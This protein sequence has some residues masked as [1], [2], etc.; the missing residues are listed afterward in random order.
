[1]MVVDLNI[2]RLSPNSFVWWIILWPLY[3][4]KSDPGKGNDS[5][6]LLLCLT[7]PFFQTVVFIYKHITIVN[8]DFCVVSKWLEWLID[9]AR[10]IIY[11]HNMF[12]MQAMIDLPLFFLLW[13]LIHCF[14][15]WSTEP[16]AI[17]LYYK[18]I[19]IVNDD[20]SDISKG[21]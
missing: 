8:D 17:K 3:Y 4:L 13:W 9:D 21:L 19:T 2:G 15:F 10:V 5:C 7:T 1:M 6:F 18:H 11:D 16:S 20:S 12:I 14:C